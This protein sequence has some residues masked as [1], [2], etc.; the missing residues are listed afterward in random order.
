MRC[1]MTCRTSVFLLHKAVRKTRQ[2]C[3][4]RETSPCLN[5]SLINAVS[6]LSGKDQSEIIWGDEA[7]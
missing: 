7:T 5:I 2:D 6:S 1:S 4:G 3:A